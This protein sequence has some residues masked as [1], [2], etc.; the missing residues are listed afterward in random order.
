MKL[1][2][3]FSAIAIATL[4]TAALTATAATNYADFPVTVKDYQGDKTSSISYGGQIARQVL[5]TSL[6]KLSKT[7]NGAANP[8]LL[9]QMQAYFSGKDEGRAILAP[10]S[11]E[12]FVLAQSKVDELSKGK[13]LAGKTYKGVIAGW[14]GKKTGVEVLEFLIE[15]AASADAGFDYSNGMDYPQL[16]SKFAMGA[17]FY[18]QAVDNYLDEKLAAD[19]KPNDKP[20]KDGAAYT[21]KEHVWDEAFGYFGA[22]INAA[23][24]DAK[25]AYAI[26]K[27]K[28]EIFATADLNGNGKIDLDTEM[29][30]AHAYYAAGAD[31]AGKSNYLNVITKAFI[32]GRQ[33]ITDAKGEKLSAAQRSDLSAFA[34]VIK[35]NWELVIAEAAFKYAG[36]VYGDALKLQAGVE[37]NEDV[38]AAFKKYIHHWGEL[39]GFSMALQTGGKD[40]GGFAVSLNRL[41]GY[42]PVLLGNTQVTGIDAKGNYQQESSISLNEFALHMLKVQKLL[43]DKY[44][45][46]A[47]LND[48]LENLSALA[49]KLGTGKSTEND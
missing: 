20:Y 6:M 11:Q 22:P 19:V 9:A 7:G 31:K 14:P 25:E 4:S 24:L 35:T 41:I 17:I 39:K 28:K 13:N 48:K 43:S 45:L 15:K 29:L 42:S 3:L 32:D 36:S 38:K 18:N 44:P 27:G 40:L 47:R 1:T 26:A 23:G 16:I 21:G 49:A 34:D 2:R 46:K 12:G 5:H 33:L 10:V 37:K 30:Y 8:E